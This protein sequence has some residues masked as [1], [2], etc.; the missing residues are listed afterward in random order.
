MAWSA[1][2]RWAT[3]AWVSG[4]AE[5]D[6]RAR[7]CRDPQHHQSPPERATARA[8]RRRHQRPGAGSGRQARAQLS[9]AGG[10][11]PR[12]GGAV[13]PG[14]AA[15][16]HQAGPTA[17]PAAARHVRPGAG[18]SYT[19]SQQRR[20]QRG[21]RR[22]ARGPSAARV[23]ARPTLRQV[24]SECRPSPPAPPR[25]SLPPCVHARPTLRQVDCMVMSEEAN[26]LAVCAGE[27]VHVFHLDTLAHVYRCAR[28]PR[29]ALGWAAR[30]M[31]HSGKATKANQWCR[32]AASPQAG[33]P[34]GAGADGVLLRAAP[35][36][37]APDGG[38]GP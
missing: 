9:S 21:R 12:L 20:D 23:R 5:S 19:A 24:V 29:C 11:H 32:C 30:L 34:P 6:S 31:P 2:W 14:A 33:G 28:P 37:L 38:G 18:A 16:R 10:G 8:S 13:A 36:R 25:S 22:D 7:V 26:S 17:Q 27:L 1:Q 15:P 3:H 4:G 35:A